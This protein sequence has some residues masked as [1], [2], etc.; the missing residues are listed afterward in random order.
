MELYWDNGKENGSY[1]IIIGFW[2]LGFGFRVLQFRVL[3]F[4]V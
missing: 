3:E 1:F 4:R 2:S